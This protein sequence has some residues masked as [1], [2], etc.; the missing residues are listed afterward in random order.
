MRTAIVECKH[1]GVEYITQLSGHNVLE[2]PKKYQ[3]REYCP[4]CQ[5]AIVD[6][7]SLISVKF[8]NKFVP[9]NE[10]TLDQLLEWEQANY[11]EE[12]EK[13]IKNECLFPLMKK[14]FSEVY[15]TELNESSISKEIKGRYEH[16]NKIF[17]CLYFPSKKEEVRITVKMKVNLE[18]NEKVKYILNN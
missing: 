6:A 7:L 12:K 13:R 15:D 11:E 10:V 4:E 2:T 16:K 9:T 1:C 3:S 5:K 17:H 18:T 14:V 8:K